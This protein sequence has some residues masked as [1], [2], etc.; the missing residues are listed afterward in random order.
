MKFREMVFSVV[1]LS[2]SIGLYGGYGGKIP[3]VN[4]QSPLD[5]QS[6]AT[7]MTCDANNQYQTASLGFMVQCQSWPKLSAFGGVKD[8]GYGSLYGP[9]GLQLG[10][11]KYAN[12]NPVAISSQS[13]NWST[14]SLTFLN[15]S[16]TLKTWVSRL[17]SW[18]I[19]S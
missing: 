14:N 16:S 7:G 4:A 9:V 18:F 3:E 12:T 6:S 11:V 2:L 15:G 17:S 10:S 5:W 8:G 1:I 13:T 19:I